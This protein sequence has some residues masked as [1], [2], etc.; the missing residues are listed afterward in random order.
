M[1]YV[2]AIV[3]FYYCRRKRF[4]TVKKYLYSKGIGFIEFILNRIKYLH[5][6][7]VQYVPINCS[8]FLNKSYFSFPY[9]FLYLL[10]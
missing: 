10:V 7:I 4:S 9:E 3:L 6:V 8:Q 5:V 2:N 1:T